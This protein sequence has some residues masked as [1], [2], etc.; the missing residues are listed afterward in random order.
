LALVLPDRPFGRCGHGNP[1]HRR[2]D[3]PL[4]NAW[5]SSS[6]RTCS[7]WP[8]LYESGLRGPSASFSACDAVASLRHRTGVSVRVGRVATLGTTRWPR[9]RSIRLHGA[10]LGWPFSYVS[11]RRMAREI[12]P[13]QPDPRTDNITEGARSMLRGILGFLPLVLDLAGTFLSLALNCLS[14]ALSL[15]AHTHDRL[16]LCPAAPALPHTDRVP[17]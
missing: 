5:R 9:L 2:H 14:L 1:N 13:G 17:S 10:A 3:D 6:V 12:I 7:A 8:R 15:L 11:S 16:L 4:A